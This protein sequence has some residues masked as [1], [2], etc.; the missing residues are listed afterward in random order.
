[1]EYSRLLSAANS[2]MAAMSMG[3][4]ATSRRTPLQEDGGEEWR[5]GIRTNTMTRKR[6]RPS[7]RDQES[8]E[9]HYT[10][11]DFEDDGGAICGQKIHRMPT[12]ADER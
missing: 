9:R 6:A 8:I 3:F 10:R 12:F 1:V 5:E 7:G 4:P 11:V 2:L